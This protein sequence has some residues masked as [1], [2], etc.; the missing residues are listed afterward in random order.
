MSYQSHLDFCF[1][2]SV[3]YEKYKNY[4]KKPSFV[5]KPELELHFVFF[6][7][8]EPTIFILLRNSFRLTQ[9]F[10]LFV[11]EKEEVW[12]NSDCFLST[13]QKHIANASF[14]EIS[15]ALW[16][17]WM[18]LGTSERMVHHVS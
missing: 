15:K 9:T 4:I 1:Q 7:V 17:N 11:Y 5:F 2:F 12:I 18:S 13:S 3:R 14:S 6:H 8:I 10:S 16:E